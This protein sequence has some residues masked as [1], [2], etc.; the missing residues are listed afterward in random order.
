MKLLKRRNKSRAVRTAVTSPPARAGQPRAGLVCP[1][2]PIGRAHGAAG[3]GG[4]AGSGYQGLAQQPQHHSAI[5]LCS[6]VPRGC[7]ESD[8][9]HRDSVETLALPLGPWHTPPCMHRTIFSPVHHLASCAGWMYTHFSPSDF[10]T[11][12]QKA[13]YFFFLSAKFAVSVG[14]EMK[15][16][17]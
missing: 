13:E 6:S 15:S 11:L 16:F 1:V 12:H 17:Q 10:L 14:V 5:G 2:V 8:Q 3:A 9:K 7:R 4:T